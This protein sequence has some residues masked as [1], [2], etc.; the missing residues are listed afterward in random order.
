MKRDVRKKWGKLAE[1]N[2]AGYSSEKVL[3]LFPF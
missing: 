1:I 2:K 3:V